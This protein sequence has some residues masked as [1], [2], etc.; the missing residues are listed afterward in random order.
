MRR[1]PPSSPVRCIGWW[2]TSTEPTSFPTALRWP[3][4]E[5][6]KTFID[7]QLFQ[8]GKSL[9]NQQ[10]TIDAAFPDGK[11]ICAMHES[12]C[13][14]RGPL[15]TIRIPRVREIALE[16]LVE[17]QVAPP[18]IVDY[19]A[20]LTRSCEHTMMVAGETGTGKTTLLRCLGTQFRPDESIISVEDTP[21]LNYDHQY[22]RSLVSRPAKLTPSSLSPLME[23]SQDAPDCHL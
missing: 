1:R 11:R 6:Y 17:N 4:K 12:V 13:G 14:Q 21:E 23:E 15:L 5:A 2:T 10:H 8:L 16:M 20:A 7:R 3:N 22:Y 19:L 9:T 18:L